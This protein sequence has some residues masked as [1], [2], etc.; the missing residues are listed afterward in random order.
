MIYKKPAGIFLLALLGAALTTVCDGVHVYTQT[1]SYPDPFLFG[2]AWWVYPGFVAAFLFM[3][4]LYVL[5]VERLPDA[6]SRQ[7]SISP[8]NARELTEALV[9]FAFVY[10]LS[11]FGNFEPVFLSVIFYG[12]FVVRWVLTYDRFWL[13][14]LSIM[15]ATGGM[16]TEGLLASAGLV[17]YRHVDIFHVP[18]WLGGLYVHG[19]FALR[20]GLRFFFYGQK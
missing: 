13:F 16:S 3:S 1:L 6:V 19:A 10:V 2:Q 18:L 11:G 15:M 17:T 14:I 8:G 7:D 9:T 4:L 20:A 12:T 5:V